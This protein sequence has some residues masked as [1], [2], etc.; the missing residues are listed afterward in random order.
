MLDSNL[1]LSSALEL[2]PRTAAEICDSAL[3]VD[4]LVESL[5]AGQ[6]F[7]RKTLCEYLGIGESTLSG[8]IKDG[9]IPRMAK[10]ALV[11]L[12][13]QQLLT[14]QIRHLGTQLDT[15][16]NDLRVA[17]SGDS[18]QVC[19]YREDEDGEIVGR[20]IA[21]RIATL[22]DA[23][24]LASGRRAL[25]VLKKVEDSGVFEY[26]HDMSENERFIAGVQAA[27]DE[28]EAHQLSLTD[29]PRWQT[30]FGKKARENLLNDLLDYDK[31]SPEKQP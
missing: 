28:V 23:R 15:A 20:V 24:L 25:R 11:L 13:V 9:R 26:V 18:Y 1:T 5:D 27:E 3:E 30:K 2:Q 31:P 22:E 12:E 8:W 19:E 16:T 4:Q 10:N 6:P 7:T 14:L 21:D 29:Y 17:R